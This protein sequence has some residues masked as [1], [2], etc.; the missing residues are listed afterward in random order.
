MTPRY[1]ITV[2]VNGRVELF[3]AAV[4]APFVR[5]RVTIGRWGALLTLLLGREI[6]VEVT[7]S[8]D[9]ATMHRVLALRDNA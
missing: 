4:P 6:D 2:F 3:E 1:G 5:T 7:V 9:R 8:A